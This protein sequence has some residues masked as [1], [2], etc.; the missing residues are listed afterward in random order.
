MK[1]LISFVFL[2][3]I[4]GLLFHS[5]SKED[6]IANENSESIGAE[7]LFKIDDASDK[8]GRVVITSNSHMRSESLIDGVNIIG[9]FKDQN[10]A[11]NEVDI[12]SINSLD[13]P[14]TN[15]GRIEHAL[16]LPHQVDEN[17]FKDMT[18]AW[19]NGKLQLKVNSKQIGKID[20]Q[21][22]PPIPIQPIYIS[23]R[24]SRDDPFIVKWKPANNVKKTIEYVGLMIIYRPGHSIPANPNAGLPDETITLFKYAEDGAGE[25]IVPAEELNIFPSGGE[26][27]TY[28]ARGQQETVTTNGTQQTVISLVSYTY[29]E[30]IEVD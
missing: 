24:V 1:Y 28:L 27:Y 8:T 29:S 20:K 19:I 9:Q 26:V 11:S 30:G 5:C 23:E 3:T 25:I 17:I 15:N 4:V 13:I 14:F 2:F 7:F 18:D 12:F 6:I 10:G 21:I 22:T 16:N